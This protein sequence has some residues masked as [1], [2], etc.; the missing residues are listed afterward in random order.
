MLVAAV[1]TLG[2]ALPMSVA[3]LAPTR[4]ILTRLMREPAW[5]SRAY[6]V[7]GLARRPDSVAVVRS[8]AALDPS[9]RVRALAEAALGER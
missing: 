1:L 9:P 8:A 3:Q 2:I 5:E 7:I 4:E 6:A